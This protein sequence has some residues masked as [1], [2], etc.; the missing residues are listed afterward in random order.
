MVL[1]TSKMRNYFYLE[2]GGSG[3]V[4]SILIYALA[5]LVIVF[6][7]L[8]VIGKI[9]VCQRWTSYL[10]LLLIPIFIIFY[11]III[12]R[13]SVGKY[14]PYFGVV[15]V[16]IIGIGIFVLLSYIAI[17]L[18]LFPKNF[19]KRNDEDKERLSIK[20]SRLLVNC[21][22]F[23][24]I[25]YSI[26]A[27]AILVI[28]TDLAAF[29]LGM[30]IFPSF[31]LLLTPITALSSGVLF[32]IAGLIFIIIWGF[33]MNALLRASYSAKSVRKH[34]IRYLIFMFIPIFNTISLAQISFELRKEILA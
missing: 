4:Y 31:L 12:I 25:L 8:S 32:C 29:T 16:A 21:A 15:P 18:N 2:K 33:S 14:R 30:F 3:V 5:V 28:A 10:C 9:K 13:A 7:Y 6:S 24:S 11:P 26:P 1:Y 34:I 23:I 20:G 17:Q 27:V 22:L 19:L